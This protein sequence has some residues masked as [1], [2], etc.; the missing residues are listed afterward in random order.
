MFKKILGLFVTLTIIFSSVVSVSAQ[1]S[2]LYTLDSYKEFLAENDINSL[3]QFENLEA[4]QQEIILGYINNPQKIVEDIKKQDTPVVQSF[5]NI[6]R[7]AVRDGR[8][9]IISGN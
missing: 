7:Q 1:E 9:Y 8:G 4:Y 5:K 3:V 6:S 2:Q